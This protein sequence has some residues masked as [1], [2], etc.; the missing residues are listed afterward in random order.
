MRARDRK[1]AGI[2]TN[3]ETFAIQSDILKY[4]SEIEERYFF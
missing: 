2:S 1:N 3:L 4:H